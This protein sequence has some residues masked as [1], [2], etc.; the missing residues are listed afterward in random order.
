MEHKI[1]YLTEYE[2]S[3]SPFGIKLKALMNQIMR[4]FSR[5]NLYNAPEALILTEDTTN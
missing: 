1:Y 3:K 4:N 5:C 2:L